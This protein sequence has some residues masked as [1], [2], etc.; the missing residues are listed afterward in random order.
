MM[1]KKLS[2]PRIGSLREPVGC[3][4]NESFAALLIATGLIAFIPCS[5]RPVEAQAVK[6]VVDA[7]Q[8]QPVFSLP[9][10][11]Y[12]GT[13]TVTITVATPNSSIFYTT[14]GSTPTLSS[15]LYTGGIA[16]D[17]SETLRAISAG[18]SVTQSL[19][20]SATYTIATQAPVSIVS[21]VAGISWSNFGMGGPATSAY[22]PFPLAVA[23]DSA[24]NL[25]VAGNFCQIYKVNLA[26]DVV[27][28]FAGT[29]EGGDS[30]NGQL[31][32]NAQFNCYGALAVDSSG[33]L[34]LADSN[35]NV[36]WKIEAAT[37]V[38]TIVAG[39]GTFGF[40]GDGGAAT[41]A[42]LENPQGVAVDSSGNLYISDTNNRVV[43]KVSVAGTISTIAGTPGKFGEAGNGGPATSALLSAPWGVAMDKAGNLYIADALDEQVRKVD[44]TGTISLFAGKGTLGNTGDHGPATAAELEDPTSLALDASGD[45]YICETNFN[46][47]RKVTASTGIITT[48]AG[49]GT[50][51]YSGDGG[52]ATGASLYYPFGAAVDAS[53]RLYIADFQNYRVRRV[54]S[55]GT[56]TTVAG[57]GRYTPLPNGVA[58]ISAPLA[59]MYA[60]N[61]VTL[62]AAGDIFFTDLNNN[63][64]REVSVKDGT[65][66]TFAGTGLMG[67]SGD[68]GPATSAELFNPDALA[69]D[70]Q[71]DLYIA[72]YNNYV[73][74]K[75]SASTG[76]ISTYAGNGTYGYTGDNGPATSAELGDITALAVDA[77]GDL[78]IG[79]AYACTVRMVTPGGTITTVAGQ[80]NQCDDSPNGDGGPATSASLADAVEALAVDAQG[81]LY[82]GAG[83]S[84]VR[85]VNMS[86]GVISTVAGNGTYGYSGDGKSALD[87]SL[88]YVYGLAFDAH[89]DLYIEDDQA[90]RIVNPAGTINSIA[91][92]AGYGYSGDGGLATAAQITPAGVALDSAS[93]VYFPD[94]T[95]LRIRKISQAAAVAAQAAQPVL[96][97][98]AGPYPLTQTVTISDSTPG[99]QIFFTL[100]G[101]TPNPSTSPLYLGP[102]SL[103]NSVTVSAIAIAPGYSTSNAASASYTFSP[104]TQTIS[105]AQPKTPVAYAAAPIA[106]SA[107][108]SSG[109]PVTFSVVSGP[110]ILKGSA[111][112]I[113]GAGTVVVAADQ[114]GNFDYLSAEEVTRTIVVSPAQLVIDVNSTSRVYGA[115]NPAFSGK[116]SGLLNGDRVTVIYSTIATAKSAVGVYPI[117]ARL[118]GA[119]AGNYT[120]TITNGKLTVTKARL[121]IKVENATRVYGK[122]NPVFNGT[123]TGLLNGDKV[124]AAYSTT[125]TIKS[126]VGEYPITAKISGTAAVNY[127]PAITEGVLTVTPAPLAAPVFSPKAGDYAQAQKV[128]VTDSLVDAAIYYTTNGTAPSEKSTR[129]TGPITVSKKETLKAIA[130]APNHLQSPVATAAYVVP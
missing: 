2:D 81:N 10:G 13:Q 98:V 92:Q 21:T 68:G 24:G 109:L 127:D 38:M 78:F 50:A 36:V 82:I 95:G 117:T 19:V 73:I 126:P 106:L 84:S 83:A 125:A 3:R 130:T 71:G 123:V 42:E 5:C 75:V 26:T 93:N 16:I 85:E 1:E 17:S 59:L 55:G 7:I 51:A 28:L 104:S 12:V 87:A 15:S 25:Y 45:L 46:F 103:V 30:G 63:V 102:L 100:D 56:I 60:P 129:Y 90:I 110:A 67:Y 86:T 48:I 111:L 22:L 6:A 108:A 66:S 44:T 53:G 20:T 94:Q 72:D 32:V 112:T 37:G 18:R 47:V 124:I 120:P 70:P 11:T 39:D 41:K 52:P 116:L 65:I 91:G 74:R 62:D 9:G 105:F 23:A 33:N 76:Q 14:D 40:S 34:Y 54:D 57:N 27:S 88:G 49:D 114:S 121:A 89:G 64:V 101:S 107:T 118:S 119:A 115:A 122:A 35:N 80:A 43:R 4:A 58:A 29:S 61:A 99:A 69:F 97:P 8:A 31:A 128:T 113:T 96:T 79:D 77:S